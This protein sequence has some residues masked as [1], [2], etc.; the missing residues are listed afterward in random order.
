MVDATTLSHGEH[1]SI[2]QFS[3]SNTIDKTPTLDGIAYVGVCLVLLKVRLTGMPTQVIRTEAW[4]MGSWA[5]SVF[6]GTATCT[7]Y[8][9]IFVAPSI[10]CK[11]QHACLCF[12]LRQWDYARSAACSGAAARSSHLW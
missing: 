9:N 2:S 5:Q 4:G 11:G 7:T 10:A 6:V 12:T 3:S 1:V 8:M